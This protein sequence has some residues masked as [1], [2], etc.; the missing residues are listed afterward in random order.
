[1]ILIILSAVI[2]SYAIYKNS[3]AKLEK[4]C[5]EDKA[6]FYSEI[7]DNRSEREKG[8]S[9][10]E[11]LDNN[12]G[13][14]FIFEEETFPGFWMKDMNFP[15]DILWINK[16]KEIIGIEKSIQPCK[17]EKECPVFYPNS[18]IKYALEINSGFSEVYGFEKGNSV[19][20]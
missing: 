14:L 10:R 20:F 12:N 17:T 1:M 19:Y 2:V 8:L 9:G 3:S 18:R 13:M 4:V 7:A 5:I 15:I 16:N 11:A 6:C